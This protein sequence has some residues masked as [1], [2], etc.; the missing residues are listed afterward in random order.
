VLLVVSP[1]FAF[2]EPNVEAPPLFPAAP[3]E[4]GTE[5]PSPTTTFIEFPGVTESADR[6]STAPPPPPDGQYTLLIPELPLAPPPTTK[7]SAAVTPAGTVHSQLP[8]VANVRTVSP[9][10]VVLVV[11]HSAAFAGAERAI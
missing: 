3:I 9:P 7:T 5:P 11:K 8:V 2:I 10:T 4:L 6:A 1:P